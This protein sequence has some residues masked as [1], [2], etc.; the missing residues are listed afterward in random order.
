MNPKG[1][2]LGTCGLV[3]IKGSLAEHPEVVA[4]GFVLL[5]VVGLEINNYTIKV[6]VWDVI[7]SH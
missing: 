6:S 3:G 1:E 4:L 7:L 2:N 5:P